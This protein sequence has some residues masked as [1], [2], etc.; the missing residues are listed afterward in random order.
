MTDVIA[1]YNKSNAI[2]FI[3]IKLIY[4]GINKIFIKE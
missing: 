4:F 1:E 3:S 2:T